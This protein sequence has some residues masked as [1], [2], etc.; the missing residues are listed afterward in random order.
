[1]GNIFV[2]PDERS[3]KVSLIDLQ[4]ISVLPAFLQAQWPIFLKPPHNY[5]YEKGIHAVKP[6]DDFDT[7]D[8]DDKTL[9]MREWTQAKLTKAYEIST[10]LENKP[11]HRATNIPRI[12]REI[13][14]R[15]GEVS[16]I[17]VLPLRA[18]LIELFQNW[19]E[20]GFS[21][22]CPLSFTQAQIEAHDRQFVAYQA[23]YGVR[24]LARECLGTDAEGWVAPG[25]DV[26]E[27]RAQNEELLTMYVESVAGEKSADQAR[28]MWPFPV[29]A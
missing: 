12:F 5:D 18:C 25:L 27:K 16:Q 26:G 10:L 17:G 22:E 24:A 23:W 19:S 20:L 3:R 11:A 4:S 2:D 6:H 7:L 1:M 9:A 28:A 13:F 8:P 29:K 15:C 14:L 21:S